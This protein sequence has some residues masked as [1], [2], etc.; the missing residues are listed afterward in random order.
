M[1]KISNIVAGVMKWGAWGENLSYSALEQLIEGCIEIGVTT[2][3][4]ADIYG[5]YTEEANFGR[6]LKTKP[7]LRQQMQIITKCDICLVTPNRPQYNIKSY[8]TSKAHILQSVEN[9]LRELG[10]DY[11]DALLIHRPDPLMNAD[12]IAEAF[13]LLR[14]SGKVLHFGVSNFLPH[15]LNLLNSRFPIEINQIEASALHLTPFLDGTLDSC[16][17]HRIV[18]MAWSPLGG[19]KIFSD[20]N[21]DAK[22]I[23]VR[24]TTATLAQKY[25]CTSEQILIAWLL[26]HPSGI[27]PVLGTS[28]LE[29]IKTAFD[30]QK[31]VLSREDWFSLWSASTG[32]DVP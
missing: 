15:H 31:I 1:I 30:A 23:R 9:S 2:F 25:N 22:I 8:D 6:V 19:G 12:E 26:R 28:K 5:H 14:D 13:T 7:S 29:R 32:V 3:D 17:Q 4:H 27:I 24:K 18:P 11:L 21:D 20:T 16:Q 10:T